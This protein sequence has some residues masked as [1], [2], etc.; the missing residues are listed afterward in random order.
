MPGLHRQLTG[1]KQQKGP[2]SG[3][4]FFLAFTSHP[5]KAIHSWNEDNTYCASSMW[6]FFMTHFTWAKG[7]PHLFNHS[8]NMCQTPPMGSTTAGMTDTTDSRI[9]CQILVNLEL[10]RKYGVVTRWIW[11]SVGNFETLKAWDTPRK[12][13]FHKVGG[14]GWVSERSAV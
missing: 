9:W 14:S 2:K 6:I 11:S 4:M 8:I 5:S 3:L 1:L 12:V 7:I 13:S 10:H